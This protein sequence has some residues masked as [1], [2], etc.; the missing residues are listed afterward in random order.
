MEGIVC[1]EEFIEYVI[2]VLLIDVTAFEAACLVLHTESQSFF[3]MLIIDYFQ[4]C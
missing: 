1:K 4:F 3:T 2:A